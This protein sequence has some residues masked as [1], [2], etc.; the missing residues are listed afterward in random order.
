MS[1]LERAW[2]HLR[3]CQERLQCARQGLYYFN[4]VFLHEQYVLAALSRVWDATVAMQAPAIHCMWCGHE[5]RPR[6]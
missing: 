1:E 6:L 2:E 4:D 5:C 3:D